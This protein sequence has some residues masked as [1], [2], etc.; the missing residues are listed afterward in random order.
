MTEE[1]AYVEDWWTVEAVLSLESR[2]VLTECAAPGRTTDQA[3]SWA[4]A[5]WRREY[6]DCQ[7]VSVTDVY[8]LVEDTGEEEWL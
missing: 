1:S 8:P 5:Y 6:R 4:S 2:T 7:Y 3:A